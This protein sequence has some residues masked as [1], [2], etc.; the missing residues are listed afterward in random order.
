MQMQRKNT[1][2]SYSL[3]TAI[4]FLCVFMSF[5]K[6]SAEEA[7]LTRILFVFDASF[8]MYGQWQ[9]GMKMDL[10]KKILSQFLDSIKGTPNLEL[11]LRPYGHQV[12]L[13]PERSC[14]DTKLEVPFSSNSIPAIKKRLSYLT[15]KGT[16]PI[17]YTLEQAAYDFPE[18]SSDKVRNIII[19]ITDGLEECDGDPCAVSRALQAKGV[20]LKPF[21]IGV[22]LDLDYI[23][24]FGCI[25]KFY[26][27]SS[28]EGFKNI[29]DIV[30]S[31]ALNNTTTQVNLNDEIG[32]PTETDVNMTFYDEY[33]GAIRYNYMHTI[34][35]YGYPDTLIIDALGTYKMV[36]HTIPQ[37]VKDSIEIIPSV[38]NIIAVDAAQ[39]YLS[40]SVVGNNYI[41]CIVRQEGKM[42]TLHVQEFNKQEKYLV[43]KYDLE[44]LTV[45]RIH[46]KGVD[47]SQSKTTKIAIP[48]AGKV[49]INK[50][51]SGVGSLY[52]E[53]NN[54][55]VWV[56]NL[57]SQSKYETLSLQPGRYRVEFRPKN[58]RESIYTV[59]KKFKVK[60]GAVTA[61]SLY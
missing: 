12:P 5:G 34:N 17:A 13:R 9:S 18:P 55:L 32:R 57:E 56:M 35:N 23:N 15:P 21:V 29:L 52:L 1:L 58:A 8:S 16:T 3:K 33:S 11:A 26:D 2:K 47:I 31:Q 10:S 39:G 60:S 22:G 44:I 41:Q 24:Q 43:G 4:A 46:L 40:L 45:P 54:E 7:P 48:Q 49:S 59:E 6:M 37:I 27:A 38:H 53:R 42:E 20:I 30:V 19:L 36:V 14:T 61:V 50:K 28:E 51:T 25:G